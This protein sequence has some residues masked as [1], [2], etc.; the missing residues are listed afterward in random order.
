MITMEIFLFLITEYLESHRSSVN[1][2]EVIKTSGYRT[3]TDAAKLREL[4]YSNSQYHISSLL[5]S[6]EK[7]MLERLAE[8]NG[9][10]QASFLR[11]LIQQP[12]SAHGLEKLGSMSL[13]GQQGES[14]E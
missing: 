2:A 11:R 13:G 8:V 6:A 12:A 7:R 9:E 10:S 3:I 14:N 4:G 5:L 1:S